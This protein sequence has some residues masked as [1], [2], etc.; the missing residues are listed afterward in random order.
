MV[1]IAKLETIFYH[2][3]YLTM[4]FPFHPYKPKDVFT[5]FFLDPNSKFYYL[6]PKGFH[7]K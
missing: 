6:I 5:S 3:K 2:N 7:T 4:V 1:Q